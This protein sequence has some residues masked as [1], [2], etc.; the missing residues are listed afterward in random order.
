M[1]ERQLRTNYFSNSHLFHLIF[2]APGARGPV[3]LY[4]ALALALPVES[5]LSMPNLIIFSYLDNS[6]IMCTCSHVC[7][8]FSQQ[9]VLPGPSILQ[10]PS[11]LQSVSIPADTPCIQFKFLGV[12]FGL[13]SN[14][15]LWLKLVDAVPSNKTLVF[16]TPNWNNV[17]SLPSLPFPRVPFDRV[18]FLGAEWYQL[19]LL[20]SSLHSAHLTVVE[21]SCLIFSDFYVLSSVISTVIISVHSYPRRVQNV[22]PEPKVGGGGSSRRP[23]K[24]LWPP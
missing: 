19:V 24:K 15:L 18:F 3:C 11:N 12:E 8:W 10:L 14:K 22:D 21:A 20:M 13:T 5:L 2:Q 7:T 9:S 6:L 4:P 23:K 17:C 1:A 16:F